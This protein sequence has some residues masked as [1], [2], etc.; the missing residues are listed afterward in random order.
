MKKLKAFKR[1]LALTASACV[2]AFLPNANALT[3]SAEGP[4]TYY[5]RN[6]TD[7][8]GEDDWW[9]QEGSSWNDQA[10]GSAL[11]YMYQNLKNG[12]KVVVDGGSDTSSL[13]FDV[14]LSNLTIRNTSGTIAIVSVSGGIDEC[15]FL[16]DSLGAV[17]GN[18]TNAHVHGGSTANFNSNVT[19]LYSYSNDPDVKPTI[20]VNGTVARF[21]AEDP[22]NTE[23]P[24]GTN[25]AANSF[26]LENGKLTTPD[27]KYTKGVSGAP[28]APATQPGTNPAASGSSAASGEY[29]A[30]PK[31]GEASPMAWLSSAAVLC[32]GLSLIL[33]KSIRQ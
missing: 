20:G 28:A 6:E 8:N 22:Y 18:V 31:T 14:H 12:D 24:C 1:L 19:N 7:E 27:D 21:V 16:N 5:I 9:Y 32:L 26:Y 2:L 30:V 33:R 29:D 23:P 17:T 11:Y 4:V 15:Y 25:F 3:A 13:E 10:G